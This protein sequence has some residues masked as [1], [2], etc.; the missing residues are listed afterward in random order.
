MPIDGWKLEWIT[1]KQATTTIHKRKFTHGHWLLLGIALI[2]SGV[3]ISAY[4]DEAAA[5]RP[6]LADA[7][8][9]PDAHLTGRSALAGAPND[10]NG[11]D[12]VGT[13]ANAADTA[14]EW[15]T[16]KVK[17]GDNLSLIFSRL[18]IS[19]QSLYSIM[20][21]GNDTRA[22]KRIRPGQT[23]RLELAEQSQLLALTYDIDPT[24]SLRIRRNGDGGFKSGLIERPV[25]HRM[26]HSSGVITSSLFESAQQAGMSDRMTMEL[27]GIFGWDID[28]ALDIREGDSFSVIYDDLYIDG[29]RLHHG[30]ILAAEF[31]NNGTTYRA[32][33]YTDANG[34]SDYYSPDGKSMRKEFLRTPVA[35]SRISS[36]FTKARYHPI[37]HHIRAHKGVDYAAPIGT[38][39]KATGDGKVAFVGRRGGYGNAIVLQHGARYSTLYGHLS[40]FARGLHRG[41]HIRQGQVI[42][43]VGMTGLATGPHLH[44]EFRVD[45][46]HRNP[47]K[48]HLPDAAPIAA[49][50]KQDFLITS[51]RFLAQLEAIDGTASVA[52][53]DR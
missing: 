6:E 16:V 20:S 11:D 47:L 9:A 24:H 31:V 36:Y 10:P 50:F 26:A 53:N 30:D 35:F 15:Q 40:R 12:R 51:R 33:R 2:V 52:L 45:G 44:Y 29:K 21:L 27:A 46:V 22:L 18:G 3:V 19:P 7:I 14:G 28:F 4:T 5:N 13:R 37:L 43:Y 32:I 42:G 49:K 38:P 1:M 17:R 25:E 39:V 41:E 8:S 48:V 23:I 34:H